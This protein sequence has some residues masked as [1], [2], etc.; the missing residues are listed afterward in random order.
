MQ[1]RSAS[2]ED[3]EAIARIY[4]EE[5]LGSTVTLDL[6]PRTVAEQRAWITSHAGAH[7]AI[8]A[9]ERG[10]IAG[11]AALSPY[12]Q[13]PAYSTTVEDSVYVSSDQRGQGVGRAL[14][15][16]LMDLGVA[17]GFHA[18]IARCSSENTASVAL[19][20]SCGFMVVGIEREIGRKFGKW[21]DIVVMERML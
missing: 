5:V 1:V 2:P 18:A 19:H 8:V 21:V 10:C 17:H 6:V 20:R 13:R 4:N 12:R 16:R 15:E 14:L 3:S 11:F 7:P 9:I